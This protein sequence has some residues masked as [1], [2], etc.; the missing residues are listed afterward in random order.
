MDEEDIYEF[1]DAEFPDISEFCPQTEFNDNPD[2]LFFND[3]K[4]RIDFVLAYEDENKKEFDKRHNSQRKK[5]S[6][7]DQSAMWWF[8]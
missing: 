4:R 1:E 8:Q 3:G 6:L 2:S 5:V 7:D